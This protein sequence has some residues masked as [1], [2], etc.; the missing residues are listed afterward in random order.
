VLLLVAV[1]ELGD[2]VA[3]DEQGL[4]DVGAL[5]EAGAGGLRLRLPLGAGQV[6]EVELAD[7]HRALLLRVL[8]LALNHHAEDGVGAAAGL[9]HL[10]L[11]N[12]PL[13]GTAL[14][15]LQRLVGVGDEGRRHPEHGHPR[16]RGLTDLEVCLLRVEEVRDALIVYFD[17]RAPDEE[18][19]LRALRPG[20][21]FRPLPL[22]KKRH[23]FLMWS[24]IYEILRGTIPGSSA[25]PCIVC[26]FPL[27]VC[28]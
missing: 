17:V 15:H 10:G 23:T 18:V 20:I 5:L 13:R 9:V 28:P 14:D 21:S 27:L 1:A 8:V 3:E 11:P 16:L 2:D 12:V 22:S 4:V 19:L 24:N 7:A 6:H 25:V 26:V